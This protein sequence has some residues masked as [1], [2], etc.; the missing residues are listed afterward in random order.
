[1]STPCRELGGNDQE[2]QRGAQQCCR[3][4]SVG[5]LLLSRVELGGEGEAAP[6][7]GCCAA[8]KD[9]WRWMWTAG[10]PP[11]CLVEKPRSEAARTRQG[12]TRSWK[13][14]GRSGGSPGSA[15]PAGGGGACGGGHPTGRRPSEGWGRPGGRDTSVL[16]PRHCLACLRSSVNALTPGELSQ[17]PQG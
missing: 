5:I 15:G 8:W 10:W 14:G 3:F 16:S 2:K 17:L 13:R 12:R 7:L 1:M 9:P 4:R 6:G 11:S